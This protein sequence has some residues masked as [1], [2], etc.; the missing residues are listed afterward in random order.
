MLDRREA[1][2]AVRRRRDFP[3]ERV[4]HQLHA[5]ADAEHRHAGVVDTPASQCGAPGSDTL[6]GPPDR[7][8][9]TGLRAADLASGVSN[10]RISE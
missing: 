1:E 7:M 9:P 8:M 10:G 6:F 4:G 3:A 5:V 2:L